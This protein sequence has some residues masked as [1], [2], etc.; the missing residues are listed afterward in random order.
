MAL[1]IEQTPMLS[2]Q[3]TI[4]FLNKMKRKRLT[5]ADKE[6]IKLINKHK[7]LFEAVGRL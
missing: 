5:K 1:P 6:I 4:E 3:G 7:K 2:K